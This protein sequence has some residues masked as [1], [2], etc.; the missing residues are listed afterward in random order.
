MDTTTATGAADTAAEA[1][2]ALNHHTLAPP[3]TGTAGW[4]DLADLYAVIGSLRGVLERLPQA[5][6][7]AAAALEPPPGVSYGTD[8]DSDP[9]DLVGTAVADLRQTVA[10]IDAA[11]RRLATV[12]TLVSHLKV[13][14]RLDVVDGDP[15]GGVDHA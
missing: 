1:V 9:D 14:R 2:R 8:D 5:L 13:E 4:E 11:R 7:Q 12:H 15:A 10:E 3:Q 6:N